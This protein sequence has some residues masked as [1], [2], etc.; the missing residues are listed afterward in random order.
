MI[1]CQDICKK[2]WEEYNEKENNSVEEIAESLA[3]LGI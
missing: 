1:P 3:E 2:K